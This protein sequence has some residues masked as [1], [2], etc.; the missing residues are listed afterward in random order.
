MKT[1][2]LE[3]KLI[4]L[5]PPEGYKC[6]GSFFIDA[7]GKRID[8][9]GLDN[10]Y[11]DRAKRRIQMWEHHDWLCLPNVKVIQPHGKNAQPL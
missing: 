10:R 3:H 2:E 1:H 6:H 4:R 8:Y 5:K 7:R 11:E 9:H